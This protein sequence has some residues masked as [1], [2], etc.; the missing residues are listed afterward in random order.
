M[1][2]YIAL[3]ALMALGVAAPAIA[4]E[5]FS[6]NLVEAGYVSNE[7]KAEGLDGSGF[8]LNGSFEFSE[9]LFG[10]ANLVD[11]D[12]DEG[13]GFS[14]RTLSVG[15]GYAMPLG[16]SVDLV[17]GFSYEN[18][19]LHIDGL[20][21]ASEK[22][23]GANVGLRGRVAESLELTGNVKYTDFGHNLD[24]FTLSVGGRYYFTPA[25]AAGIDV[26]DN[27]DGTA[28]TVALRY[29]FGRR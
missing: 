25:F 26:S 5:G 29:D 4:A 17:S 13:S 2:K 16:R 27:D 14:T 18:L 28:W 6:Y 3:G 23:F 19:R 7:I 11:A 10:F 22:G 1:R 21:S 9:S 20:G 24:D 12:Y 8:A 15:L